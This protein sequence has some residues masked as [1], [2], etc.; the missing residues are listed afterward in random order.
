MLGPVTSSSL[1]SGASWV[2]VGDKTLDLRLDHRMA[3]GLDADFGTARQDRADKIQGRGAF[4]QRRQNIQAGQCPG[5]LQRR[6]MRRQ[7]IEQ[8][9]PQ[10]L[11]QRQCPFA[12]RQCLVFKSLEDPFPA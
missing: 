8:C 4:G 10:G 11:F 6:N 9:F 2:F 12:G 1:R 3:A 7:R 5:R